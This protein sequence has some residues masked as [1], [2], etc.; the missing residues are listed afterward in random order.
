MIEDLATIEAGLQRLERRVVLQSLQPGLSA[1]AVQEAL[2]ELGLE[3]TADL[4][5]L[6]GWRDGT[7]TA[8]ASTV[9]DIHLFPGFYLLSLED[10]VANYQAFVRDDRW[11]AGWLPVFANGGGDF[12][13]LDLG[14]SATGAVRHFRIDE[15]EHPIEFNSLE[16]L[17]RT[18]ATAFEQAVFFVDENGYLE[19]DDLAFGDLAA[20]LNPDVSWWRE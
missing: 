14:S 12:Y 20:E 18:L 2:G 6:Y 13:V 4:V 11:R 16:G 8:N 19:M 7:S 1:E 3:A 9:D 5:S 17:L 15:S 10:A